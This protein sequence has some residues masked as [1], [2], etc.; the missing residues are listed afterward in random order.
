MGRKLGSHHQKVKPLS[1]PDCGDTNPESFAKHRNRRNGLQ[2]YCRFC[3]YKRKPYSRKYHYFRHYNITVEQYDA[4]FKQQEGLCAICRK[5]SE[6]VLAVDHDH[7]CCP[8]TRSCGK[9]IRGLLC[10]KCNSLLGNAGDDIQIL[11]RASEYLSANKTNMET[12]L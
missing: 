5:P 4:L 11:K 9:C 7:N 6:R 1:C 3:H 2:A 12:P 10:W 8:G